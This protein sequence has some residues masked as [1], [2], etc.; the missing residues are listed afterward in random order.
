MIFITP[1]VPVGREEKTMKTRVISIGIVL[2][3]GLSLGCSR[4]SETIVDAT[5]G[6][7]GGFEEERS[8]LPAHWLVYSPATLPS[9]KY[10]LTFDR[11]DFKEGSQSLKFSVEECSAVGGWLSPGIAQEYPAIPG[12]TYRISFWIKNEGCDYVV[13]AGGVSAKTGDHVVVD[14]AQD[15][16]SAWR[17]VEYPITIAPQYERIRFE[18][19]IRSPGRLWIDD[20]KI[21]SIASLVSTVPGLGPKGG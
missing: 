6:P 4:M 5:I 18:L 13:S 16:G 20:V 15:S 7:N 14:S 8:G 10:E 21:E 11:G 12:G 17:R 19:S 2:A 1:T 9:G 3:I